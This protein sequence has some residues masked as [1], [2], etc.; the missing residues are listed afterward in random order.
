M[1]IPATW[2]ELGVC[3][4]GSFDAVPGLNYTIGVVNG[5]N[6]AEFNAAKGIREGRFEGRDA[7]ANNL[8]ITGS[9][10]YYW[11]HFR[12]Q[13]SGYMGGTN[14]ATQKASD[15]LG[16]TAGVFGTPLYLAEANIQYNNKG[17]YA[18]AL[19]TVTAIPDADKLNA[20]YHNNVAEQMQG[21][22]A[23]AGY[24]LL[25]TT[26]FKNKQLVVFSRYESI[27]MVAQTPDNGIAND[28]LNQQY[29]FVG[30]AFKPVQG[31]IVKADYQM[32]TTGDFNPAIDSEKATG[33]NKQSSL[34]N[35][36][37]GYSF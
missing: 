37:I 7:S 3:I 22:Y 21:F 31:V 13:V 17:F 14:T 24:N 25:E 11:N 4:Y 19:A 6:G 29:V 27:N 2:R 18:K 1:L 5:L 28:A 12:M 30:L 36:G 32:I 20:V 15:T 8:A 26:A 35:I 23:E 9:L 33:Y 10:L 34:L 16:L